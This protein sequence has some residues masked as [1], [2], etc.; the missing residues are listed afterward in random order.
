MLSRGQ[1]ARSA[2]SLPRAGRPQSAAPA[3]STPRRSVDAHID[4]RRPQSAVLKPTPRSMTE[5]RVAAEEARQA[6]GERIRRR[7]TVPDHHGRPWYQAKQDEK[8]AAQYRLW[9]EGE[10]AR[11]GRIQAQPLNILPQSAAG[12]RQTAI[13]D[14]DQD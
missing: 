12:G 4:E 6:A 10:E 13:I 1:Q 7:E 8:R 3:P 5:L 9:M 11:V 14:L 2:E